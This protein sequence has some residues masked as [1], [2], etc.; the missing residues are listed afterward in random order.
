MYVKGESVCCD[1][2]QNQASDTKENFKRQQRICEL[3]VI[4]ELRYD[5]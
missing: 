5:I 2:R 4:I 3:S 1:L